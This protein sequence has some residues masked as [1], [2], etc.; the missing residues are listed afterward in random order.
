MA[1]KGLASMH[2]QRSTDRAEVRARRRQEAHDRLEQS[3]RA[4]ASSEGWRA[5]LDTRASFH[6]YSMSNT[7]LI[8]MQR[9]DATQVA[10]FRK[11]QE[12]GR[13]VRKGERGIRIMAPHTAKDRD[14]QT[15]EENVR[16][17]FVSVSVFDVGQTDGEPLPERPHEPIT[18]NSHADRL[19]A[20]EAFARSLGYSVNYDELEHCGGFCD[21]KDKRIVVEAREPANAKVRTLVHEI[22]HA[23]GVGYD[24]Y[25]RPTAEVIVDSAA[26]VVCS[27]IGLDVSGE[28][29]SYVTGWAGDDLDKL[30]DFA[31]K[32]DELASKIESA[33]IA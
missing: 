21:R 3:V 17:Y 9:P 32:V 19:P 12:L 26:H 27:V 10:G 16:T 20:L 22:A 11:W 28:T 2:S 1:Q 13:Q 29:V 33:V 31:S 4:L 24:E 6:H 23:L 30:R 14:E 8:A 5:W 18:G 15:G 25:D 7:M